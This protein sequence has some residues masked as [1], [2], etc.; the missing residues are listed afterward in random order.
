MDGVSY[1]VVICAHLFVGLY[2]FVTIK[3]AGTRLAPEN[4]MDGINRETSFYHGN[5]LVD[6]DAYKFLKRLV[7]CWIIYMNH[8]G[9]MNTVWASITFLVVNV[10]YIILFERKSPMAFIPRG[11]DTSKNFLLDLER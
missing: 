4:S 10:I 8:N 5:N 11:N 2:F 3:K 6:F 1:G 9:Y 7:L